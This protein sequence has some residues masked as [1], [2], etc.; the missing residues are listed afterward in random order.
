MKSEL[1][2]FEMQLGFLLSEVEVSH[3][4]GSGS[5]FLLL[6][7]SYWSLLLLSLCQ[8]GVNSG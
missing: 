6:H 2:N 3:S 5:Y 4:G 8:E 1:W 7:S